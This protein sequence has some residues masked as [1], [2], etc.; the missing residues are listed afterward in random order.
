MKRQDTYLYKYS[1][2]S[3][4]KKIVFENKWKKKTQPN[5][6]TNGRKCTKNVN[7]FFFGGGN[8]GDFKLIFICF[9]A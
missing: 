3:I 4:M 1:M 7:L 6:K 9:S 2:T 5:K 8:T